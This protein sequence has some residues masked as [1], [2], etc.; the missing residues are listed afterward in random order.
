[1]I[2]YGDNAR[3]LGW[4]ERQTGGRYFHDA[5][6][7]GYETDSGL[8]AVFVFDLF[9]TAGCFMHIASDGSRRWATRELLIHA[10]A[11]PFI[12]C[13]FRRVTAD[14]AADNA[15]AIRMV[16][17]L[18]AVEEGRMREAGPD[19]QD[20]VLFGLLRRDCRWLP[21]HGRPLFPAIGPA[22]AG[23]VPAPAV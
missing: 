15:T 16:T 4:A 9:A 8:R 11:Y 13:R 19:G 14:I 1:M 12:T 23:Q 21:G 5:Q 20:V 7:I 2:V 10:F 17:Q 3:L 18:G 6:A 22:R